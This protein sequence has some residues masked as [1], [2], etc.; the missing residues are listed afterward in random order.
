MRDKK[1]EDRNPESH[2]KP[3]KIEDSDRIVSYCESNS[4]CRRTFLWIM[5]G[6]LVAWRMYMN[7]AS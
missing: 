1:K 6:T 2:F 7:G 3:S 4:A 5:V